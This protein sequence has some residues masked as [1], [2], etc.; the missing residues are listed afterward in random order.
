ME[1]LANVLPA[2]IGTKGYLICKDEIEIAVS[3]LN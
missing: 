3:I 2:S 1:D